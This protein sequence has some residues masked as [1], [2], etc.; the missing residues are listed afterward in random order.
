MDKNFIKTRSICNIIISL[1]IIAIGII[2]TFVL[3]SESFIFFG[4]FS[5]IIGSLLLLVL[6]TEYRSSVNGIKYKKK[7]LNFAKQDKIAVLEALADPDSF[8]SNLT[9]KGQSL[10][11]VMYHN[12]KDAYLQLFEY[13][14][15]T[16]VPC[17]RLFH[18]ETSALNR[19]MQPNSAT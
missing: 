16:F 13:I 14:P 1:L 18:H 6:K 11:L 5:I 7:T 9:D 4:I 12:K 3:K 15:H 10:M 17:S 8:D 19:F 2:C